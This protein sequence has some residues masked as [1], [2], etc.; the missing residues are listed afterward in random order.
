M[1]LTGPV[2]GGRGPVAPVSPCVVKREIPFARILVA[3]MQHQGR[4]RDAVVVGVQTLASHNL[5]RP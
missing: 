3:D 1:R 5:Q 4:L 2:I